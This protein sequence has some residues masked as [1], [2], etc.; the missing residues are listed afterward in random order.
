[1]NS[2]SVQWTGMKELIAE[3]TTAPTEI[4]QDGM[5]ILKDEL[6]AAADEIRAAY[7]QG[8]TGNL[9]RGVAVVIPNSQV[10]VGSV[11]STSPESHLYEFGTQ[12]R[13]SRG[14]NRGAVRPHPVT[15]PIA[16]KHRREMFE[17]LKEMLANMGFQVSGG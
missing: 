13:Q 10:L 14:G 9:K 17:R 15:V 16:N 2:A 6:E 4:R 5:V 11:K 1:M 8:P 12:A 3:L 7:P